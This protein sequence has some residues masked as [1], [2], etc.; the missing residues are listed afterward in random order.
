MLAKINHQNGHNQ[1]SG[2]PSGYV[3]VLRSIEDHLIVGFGKSVKPA[4]PTKGWVYS[5]A[6]AWLFLVFK[7]E[8]L[9]REIDNKGKVITLERG[10]LQGARKYLA[11]QWNWTEDQVRSF[12][13]K[14]ESEMMIRVRNPQSETHSNRQKNAHFVNIISICKYDTYQAAIG[15]FCAEKAQSE[16]DEIPDEIPNQSPQYKES[17]ESIKKVVATLEADSAPQGGSDAT[18]KDEIWWSEDGKQLKASDTQRAILED[19]A[20]ARNLDQL[21]FEVAPRIPIKAVGKELVAAVVIEVAKHLKELDDAKKKRGTRLSRDWQL[22]KRWGNWA[23]EYTHQSPDWVRDTA[24][25]FKDHWISKSGKDATKLDWEATWR[26][27]VRGTKKTANGAP[28]A[29]AP[30]S[31]VHIGKLSPDELQLLR[32][33]MRLAAQGKGDRS[34]ASRVDLWD[35]AVRR[36]KSSP[37]SEKIN[38]VH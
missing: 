18:P 4:D 34:K 35:E 1:R 14:L 32:S 16:H 23:I 31:Y 38:E 19:I 21:L 2:A 10:E 36:V 5:R 13:D 3:R 28:A 9:S 30:I 6:E 11:A 22:P 33:Y 8:F 25:K 27:W 7:A 20:G 37:A 17:K 15:K 24:A 29:S 12:L 26:N